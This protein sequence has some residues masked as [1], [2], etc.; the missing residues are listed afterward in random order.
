MNTALVQKMVQSHLKTD[1]PQINVGDTIKVFT[2]VKEN[3]GIR[4]QAFEGIVMEKR[5]GGINETIVVRRLSDGGIF[6][7]KIFAIHSPAIDKVNVT[8]KGQVRR[9]KLHYLRDRVGKQALFVKT[10][11][12]A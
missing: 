1:L 9:A 3:K 5:H 7:E 8:K 11:K 2:K 10:G 6:C 12:A 4:N